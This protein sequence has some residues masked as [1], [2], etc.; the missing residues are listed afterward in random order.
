[1]GPFHSLVH[2][3]VNGLYKQIVLLVDFELVVNHALG[4]NFW[5]VKTPLGVKVLHYINSA[6]CPLLLLVTQVTQLDTD[7]NGP[8]CET[9]IFFNHW[10]HGFGYLA[11]QSQQVD[12]QMTKHSPTALQE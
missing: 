8:C 7:G 3:K 10:C 9:V 2:F 12:Q 1:M 4:V 11:N 6:Q 5:V